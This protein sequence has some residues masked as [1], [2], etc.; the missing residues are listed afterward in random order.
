LLGEKRRDEP[1]FYY[2]KLDDMIP[3]DHLLMGVGDIL[4]A[5]GA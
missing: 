1:M 5:L 3:E 4:W 2:V